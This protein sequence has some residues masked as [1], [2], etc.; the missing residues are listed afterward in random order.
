MCRA[1]AERLVLCAAAT[2]IRATRTIHVDRAV[3]GW[4]VSGSARLA[5]GPCRAAQRQSV[6]PR[7]GPQPVKQVVLGLVA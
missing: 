4:A 1:D 6:R 2:L 3:P 5:N 7:Y